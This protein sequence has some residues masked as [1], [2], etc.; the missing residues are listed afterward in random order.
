M[1]MTGSPRRGLLDVVDGVAGTADWPARRAVD[2]VWAT[3]LVGCENFFCTSRVA[4]LILLRTTAD[5]S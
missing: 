3:A 2:G 5:T 4:P 1:D